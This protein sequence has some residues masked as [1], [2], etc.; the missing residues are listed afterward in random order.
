MAPQKDLLYHA[1]G[2]LIA[3]GFKIV[4]SELGERKR[5]FTNAEM[6]LIISHHNWARAN[7]STASNML[8]MVV[9]LH[10]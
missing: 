7:L 2:I 10:I 6:Q 4:Q 9:F 3:I 8:F 5:G 1:V